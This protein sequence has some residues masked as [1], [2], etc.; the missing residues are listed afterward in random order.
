MIYSEDGDGM[1]QEVFQAIFVNDFDGLQK[2]YAKHNLSTDIL[3]EH[4]MTPLQH[5]A[6]KGNEQIV[7]W[8]LNRGADVNSG[9]HK[10]R[11]TALHFAA[12]S[13]NPV[14]CSLLLA[15]GAKSDLTNT[16]GRTASQMGAFVGNHNC[17]A[18]ISNYVPEDE[19]TCYTLSDSNDNEPKLPP[20]LAQPVHKFIMMTNIHP[21]KVALEIPPVFLV[22]NNALKIYKVLN[23]MCER[24]INKQ[25]ETNEV[26]AFK[27]HYLASILIE[28]AKYNDLKS[29]KQSDPKEVFIKKILKSEIYSEQFLKDCIRMFPFR[30]CTIFRQ[31]VTSLTRVKDGMTALN[32]ILVMI[33]NR[34]GMGIDSFG[35]ERICGTCAENNAS[36]KC[37]KC[38]AVQ[39]CDRECQRIHWF[40][41]KKE[42]NREAS[43]NGALQTPIDSSHVAE[44]LSGLG[45][46]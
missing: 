32:V 9:K 14:V 41:H 33:G 26:M 42:C 13:G 20:E 45:I 8:L 29:E 46:K 1:T 12:L 15:A 10:Y 27:F 23:L 24:E 19:V 40:V 5:A 7:R 25:L 39:Y 28:I 34:R 36:K 35:E 43:N 3:D 31:M 22:D 37:A 6:Y 16:V 44:S 30:D 2:I 17:V 4:G 11:Y 18:V 21:V 38:K